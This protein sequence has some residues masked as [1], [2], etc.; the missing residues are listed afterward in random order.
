ML[1]QNDKRFYKGIYVTFQLAP[2]RKKNTVYLLS[3]IP[4]NEGHAIILADSL[5]RAYTSDID[6]HIILR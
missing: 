2:D 3:Y 6:E 4:L 1:Q 5:L